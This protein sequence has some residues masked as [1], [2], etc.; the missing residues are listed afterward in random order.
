MNYNV[1]PISFH[2]GIV[3]ALL[4]CLSSASFTQELPFTHYTPESEVNP[5]PSAFVTMV[6]QDR[7]GYLW[8]VVYSSGLLRYDGHAL[9][10]YSLDDGLIDLDTRM[11]IE[12]GLGRLWVGSEAGLVV[13]R[14][15]LE[16]H[17]VNERISFE[18][19]I[20]S[21][22]LLRTSIIENRLCVDRQG[23]LWIGTRDDGIIRYKFHGLDS[24]DVDTFATDPAGTGRNLEVR[25]LM[26][27]TDGN[28]WAGI[29]KGVL[30]VLDSTG[31]RSSVL[32]ARRNVPDIQIDALWS[33][34]AGTIYG[35]CFNGQVWKLRGARSDVEVVSSQL[36]SRVTSI[37]GD[38]R[39]NIWVGSEGSGMMKIAPSGPT[40]IYTRR[41]GLLG[42]NVNG[43]MEDR[44]G[45]L[46]F[47]QVGGISKLRHNYAAFGGYT[48]VSHGGA[49]PY[50]PNA[51]I[52]AVIPPS[53]RFPEVGIWAATSGAGVSFIRDDGEVATLGMGQGLKS[54]WVNGLVLDE[55]GRVWIGTT[56][57]I[58]CFT[59]SPAP[60]LPPSME[61]RRVTL[62]DRPGILSTHGFKEKNTI[63]SCVTLRIPVEDGS[64]ETVESIWFT[65]FKT[66]YCLAGGEW[67]V[68]ETASG[69][70]VAHFT[71]AATDNNGAML[72][73]TRDD[74]LYKAGPL[75]LAGLRRLQSRAIML[76]RERGGKRFGR[77]ITEPVFKLVWSETNGAP[78]NQIESMVNHSGLLWVGTPGGL[79][80]LDSST[81]VVTH[82]REKDGLAGDDVTSMTLSPST[83]S[84]WLGTNGGMTEVDPAKRTV[85]RAL[86]KQD[87]LLDNEVWF[88]SSLRAGADGTLYFG[89]AKGLALYRPEFDRKN[90]LPPILRVTQ[91]DF[92]ERLGGNAIEIRFA[93]LSFANERL[94]RYRTQ[95]DGHDD[96]WSPAKD[97]I[98]IRYTNLPAFLVP[99][100]YTFHVMASN[101]DGV[102]TELPAT[103]TFS[104][105][106]PWWF[107]WWWL[108]FN[109]VVLLVS[110]YSFL[111]YRTRQLQKRSRELERTVE[112]RTH[113]IRLKAEQI[114]QQKE[115]L[116]V[117]NVELEEKNQEIIR[118]QEQLIMQE[119]LA[120]LGALTAGIAHEIKNPLNFVNNF[121]EVS[122]EITQELIED[123]DAV[124]DTLDPK[125]LKRITANLEDIRENATRIN[126]HGK[127]ADGIVR[128]MLEHSRGK[129]GERTQV[130]LNKLVEEYSNL[131]YHG[132]QA[133]DPSVVVQIETHFDEAV[134]QV[135]AFPQDISR[136]FLN[137][138]NNACYAANERKKTGGPAF[139][140]KVSVSTK[141]MDGKV[142]VRIRD[143]GTGIP[144]SVLDKIFNPFFTTKPTGKGTGLGLSL[145]YDIVVKQH[146][147]EINVETEEG[148]FTEFIVRLPKKLGGTAGKT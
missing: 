82:L 115:E 146:A 29:G 136:V 59:L 22:E 102:W 31:R 39:G 81:M 65:A 74:G 137:I 99:A 124:K 32:D 116:A 128:G 133:Q 85:L 106:P 40:R 21:T 54:D 63:Y 15:P 38:A 55:Q 51:S 34:T 3:A 142:E 48:A 138:V 94:V 23:H 113:E 49:P 41:N 120:S 16:D 145:T 53:S 36:Q 72:I 68:F 118:T 69:L 56:G 129:T 114:N 19:R 112:E 12:D 90:T 105:Q 148:Q 35:G 10:P 1:R 147:G 50:L 73:G 91:V 98:S 84:L 2:S 97:N 33:D 123:V 117:K 141:N 43:V 83:G 125:V 100:T 76:S 18:S 9:D 52:G 14:L 26:M 27:R 57:G 30:L 58:H 135:E 121:S 44:E 95:M 104:V 119:K 46:W 6:H 139:E 70:P 4:L 61:M 28:I 17:G 92:T 107:R 66:V 47:A 88:Y 78:S 67:F 108:A 7:L 101:N 111:H 64:R 80:A 93:A 134:G 8:F 140:P 25:S 87:G 20:G 75:S 71:T 77:E 144:K 79:V 130:D 86:T 60:Q 132:M 13:S 37:K 110:T 127:R 131:A 42:E 126:E 109:V 24:V 96:D 122:L 89:T 5:L 45:N 103:Y 11:V 62:L 143:N